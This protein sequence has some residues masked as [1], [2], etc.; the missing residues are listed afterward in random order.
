MR[1]VRD[2]D[3]TQTRRERDMLHINLLILLVSGRNSAQKRVGC[4]DGAQGRLFW[5]FFFTFQTA[6]APRG[7]WLKANMFGMCTQ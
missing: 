7:H 1:L 5:V 2:M 3:A 4:A 6:P